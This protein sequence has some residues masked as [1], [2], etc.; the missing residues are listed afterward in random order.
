E[1]LLIRA[2]RA[3]VGAA[4]VRVENF[5]EAMRDLLR[6]TKA[7]DTMALDEFETKRRRWSAAPHP[8]G[9]GGWP[10]VRLNAL[11]VVRKPSVC[12]RVVCEVGGYAEARAA[13][14]KAGVDVLVARTK[15]GVL[16]FG[17]DADVRTAFDAHGITEFDLHTIENK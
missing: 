8:G 10:V 16:A 4:L 12:R 5:D 2:D 1:Q 13:V 11:P 9:S 6:L 7:I 17:R 3:G 15:A 14:E